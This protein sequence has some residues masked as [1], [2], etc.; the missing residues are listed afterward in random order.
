M[1]LSWLDWWMEE[2]SLSSWWKLTNNDKMMG[3][4]PAKIRNFLLL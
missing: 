1:M 2:G 4:V 3:E